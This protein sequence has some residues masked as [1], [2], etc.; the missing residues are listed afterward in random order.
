MLREPGLQLGVAAHIL[1]ITIVFALLSGAHAYLAYDELIGMVLADSK[2]PA[3]MGALFRA[4]TRDFLIVSAS[5]AVVYVSL[6]FAVAVVLTHRMVGPMVAIRRHIE[7]LKQGDL[8]ARVRLRKRDAFKDVARDL[9]EL[10]E[11]LEER[12]KLAGRT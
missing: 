7:A 4:Q 9:N 12:E 2:E 11:A 10:A 6:S 8:S 1:L 3:A 5:L